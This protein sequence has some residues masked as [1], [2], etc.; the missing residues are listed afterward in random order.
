MSLGGADRA[1]A[2]T[3]SWLCPVEG[4]QLWVLGPLPGP[5]LAGLPGCP[6]LLPMPMER[7]GE[8]R[9][10]KGGRRKQCLKGWGERL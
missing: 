4:A 6:S 2:S 7:E 9:K 8:G 10:G 1:E 3:P 5:S